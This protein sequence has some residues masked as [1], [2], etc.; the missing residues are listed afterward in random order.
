MRRITSPALVSALGVFVSCMVIFSSISISAQSYRVEQ[1]KSGSYSYETVKGDPYG[2]RKYVLKNGLTVFTSVNR[3]E[4]RVQTLISVRTGSKN[5]PAD[6]TGLAHYLEHMLFKGTDK[7][8]TLDYTK[9]QPLLQRIED[10]FEQ[11]RHTTDAEQRKQMYHLIDSLSSVAATYAIPG[12]YDRM[13]KRMGARGTNAHTSDDETV[14]ENDIPQNQF[15]RW[16]T[17]EAERFRNPVLRLFHTELEAVYEE[18]N[19]G[20]DNDGRVTFETLREALFPHHQYGT[21]TTIGTIEHLKNP[22]MKAI[23]QY[24]KTYYVPNNMAIVLVG[25]IDPDACVADIEQAFSA[26]AQQT[27]PNTPV[28]REEPLKA[29]VV[30]EVLSPSTE[31]IS[32]AFR[33]PGS[34]QRRDIE[35]L[36]M[37]D[38]LLSNSS[39]GLIDLNLNQKQRVLNAGCSPQLMKDYSMH[40]FFAVP[41][42]GQKL[43]D[44]RDLLLGQIEELKEGHFSEETMKAVINDLRI[45]H[46]KQMESNSNRAAIISQ[47][48]THG[49]D[50]KDAVHFVDDLST[51]TKNDIVA[52]AKKNYGNNYAVVYKRS[53]EKTVQHVEKPAITPVKINRDVESD[54]SK[55]IMAMPVKKIEPHFSDFSKD[56]QR[57]TLENGLEILSVK[58]TEN[59]LYNL[60]FVWDYGTKDDPRF[61][62][63]MQ[64]LDFI[65]AGGLSAEDIKTQLY[66]LGCSI[67]VSA[68]SESMSV[69]LSGSVENL[70]PAL[71]L[72]EMKLNKPQP[73][74]SALS[75]LIDGILRQRIN[76][77][78]NKNVILQ[79]ALLNYVTYGKRNPFTTVLSEK[80]LKSLKA[81]DLVAIIASWS[82]LK[83]RVEYYGPQSIDQVAA[84]VAAEHHTPTH[85][86]SL[87]TS[88][89]FVMQDEP[90]GKV[91]FLDF[92]MIQAEVLMRIKTEDHY[93]V[94]N[95]SF[96]RLYNEYN[97]GLSG[98]VFQTIRES[99]ALAYSVQAGFMSPRRAEDPYVLSAYIGTQADKLP[100]ALAAM[101][102]I[103]EK[104]PRNDDA[105]TNAKQSV[106]EKIESERFT[107]M[108][109]I[110]QYETLHKLGVD[111]DV[112]E[113]VYTIIPTLSFD[114]IVHQRDEK[115]K[116][117]KFSF[118]VLG[119]KSRVS[120][121][122]LQKYGEVETLSLEDVFGY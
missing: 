107:K 27:L 79:Q 33:F 49:E 14:F 74:S 16:I 37:C 115:V 71:R 97:G 3:N 2:V 51:I 53:G 30:R 121:T 75:L 29:P 34:A 64:Y 36:T 46:L 23:K 7:Y 68:G 69:E 92:D 95:S 100:E 19:R 44:L 61:S 40:R 85:L 98:V 41:R 48:Y 17:L 55:Q 113:Q 77:K 35:L 21:Q 72:V 108:A 84:I 6:A 120:M 76:I 86:E 57:K 63:A 103:L 18:K 9:E 8:G 81:E 78:K 11:Y 47:A 94:Q 83:H 43:E 65:G 26:Y 42:K 101:T 58:N 15:R 122:E 62:T 106:M 31:N 88:A 116:D 13:M 105:F 56:I 87:P 117:K 119:S 80:E 111:F 114:D 118:I 38:M 66:N 1:H 32:M 109:L 89:P 24:F 39:A 10:L 12:E 90:K 28:I 5:D 104:M 20:M 52:F 110:D 50:W 91:Y 70:V 25:D 96:S 59:S 60:N 99:K 73:D 93:S 22:S 67:R 82:G 112:R 102:D 4:P 45:S 54:F